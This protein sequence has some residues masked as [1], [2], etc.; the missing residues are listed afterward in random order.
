MR[1]RRYNRR[2]RAGKRTS[3]AVGAFLRVNI[4]RRL[5]R[6]LVLVGVNAIE[7]THLH[8]C[9]VGATAKFLNYVWHI[10]LLGQIDFP[11]ALVSATPGL[12]SCCWLLPASDWRFRSISSSGAEINGRSQ[13]IQ[14]CLAV[15]PS[16]RLSLV[17]PRNSIR[18]RN[19]A[20]FGNVRDRRLNIRTRFESFP[21]YRMP[22]LVKGLLQGSFAADPQFGSLSEPFGAPVNVS[23][24]PS[25]LTQSAEAAAVF[26]KGLPVCS[27]TGR[28]SGSRTGSLLLSSTT[29]CRTVAASTMK[30]STMTTIESTAKR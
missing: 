2:F 26:A 3:T 13:Q 29:Q 8:A 17:R 7:W 9:I 30:T 18:A 24:A 5:G 21:S 25:L 12:L 14:L 19:R 20:A 16:T 10:F 22:V 27:K 15:S 4:K 6:H 1:S 28:S 23:S 11:I